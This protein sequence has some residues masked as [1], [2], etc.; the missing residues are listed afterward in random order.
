[1]AV[2]LNIA[3]AKALQ[4]GLS[5]EVLNSDSGPDYMGRYMQNVFEAPAKEIAKRI[6]GESELWPFKK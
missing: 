4:A 3:R 2:E 5:L 6:R 1:L